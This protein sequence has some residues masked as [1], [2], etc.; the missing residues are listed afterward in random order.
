MSDSVL[1]L[2]ASSGEQSWK[3]RCWAPQAHTPTSPREL[4]KHIRWLW[5]WSHATEDRDVCR[6]LLMSKQLASDSLCMQSSF[7]R[8]EVAEVW[9]TPHVH[10]RVV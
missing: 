3:L 8:H 6:S 10:M 1:C 4:W 2:E 9:G 7:T 5:H